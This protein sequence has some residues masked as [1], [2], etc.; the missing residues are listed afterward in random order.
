MKAIR[1]EFML[2]YPARKHGTGSMYAGGCRCPDCRKAHAEQSK[3]RHQKLRGEG[4]RFK[5]YR[6]EPST[7]DERV[8]DRL[9]RLA[10]GRLE[11][12]Q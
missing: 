12:A 1:D 8:V 11:E 2:R 9:L 6:R 7:E 3:A 4:R 5:D 10:E